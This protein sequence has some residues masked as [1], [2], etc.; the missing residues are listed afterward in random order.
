MDWSGH[1]LGNQT[2]LSSPTDIAFPISTSHRDHKAAEKVWAYVFIKT[3]QPAKV[4]RALRR[5]EGVTKADG[6]FGSPDVIAI[7]EGR[8]ILSMDAVIDKIAA[9]PDVA[10]TDSKVARWI[11]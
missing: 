9:T 1:T 5:I 3:K 2:R 6:L 7:V 4:V 11:E 8:D 10:D